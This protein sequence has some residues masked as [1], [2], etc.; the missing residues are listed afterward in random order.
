M[1]K[2]FWGIGGDFSC[3]LQLPLGGQLPSILKRK[4]SNAE[5]NIIQNAPW[6][7]STKGSSDPEYDLTSYA[8]YLLKDTFY[9]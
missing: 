8:F 6:V 3:T 4:E 1:E 5:T 2:I 9:R 7:I